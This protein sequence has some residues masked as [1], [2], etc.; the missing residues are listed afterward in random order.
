M[1]SSPS[2][3]K[4]EVMLDLETM[5]RTPNAPI[6]QVAAVAWDSQTGRHV[7]EFHCHVSFQDEL[8][9]GFKPDADTVLWWMEQSESAR[10]AII[11]GQ[12]KSPLKTK[13]MV[14]RLHTWVVSNQ[15]SEVNW[16]S[17]GPAF[18]SSIMSMHFACFN[19]LPPWKHWADRCYRTLMEERKFNPRT[20]TRSGVAHNALDDC[21]HQIKCLQLAR[22]K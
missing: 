4:I 5:G 9:L 7:H 19:S 17:N 1:K 11:D 3:Q 6:L 8:R 16:W 10:K 18:D 13:D 12:T 21:A 22:S 14:Q 15:L 20:V 2:T